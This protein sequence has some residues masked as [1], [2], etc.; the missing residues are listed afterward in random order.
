M[1]PLGQQRPLGKLDRPL[2]AD[3]SL[4]F[5]GNFS[6]VAR[7]QRERLARQLQPRREAHFAMRLNFVRDRLRNPPDR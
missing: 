2:L 1:Q 3:K 7:G 6:V 5:R 4:Q